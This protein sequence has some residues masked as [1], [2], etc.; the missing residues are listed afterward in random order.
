VGVLRAESRSRRWLPGQAVPRRCPSTRS[1]GER[2][3][4]AEKRK[5]FW[6]FSALNR[7]PRAQDDGCRFRRFLGDALQRGAADNAEDKKLCG[8]SPRFLRV[9]RGSALNGRPVLPVT[10]RRQPPPVPGGSRRPI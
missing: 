9:L 5:T 7:K 2:G 4:N 1:R 8:S 6:E 3:E 10:A